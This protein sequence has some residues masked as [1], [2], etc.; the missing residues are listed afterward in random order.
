MI[1]TTKRILV[2]AWHVSYNKHSAT[3]ISQGSKSYFF[4]RIFMFLTSVFIFFQRF[5]SMTYTVFSVLQSRLA[6]RIM[7]STCPFVRSFVCL[8]STCKRYTLKMSEAISMQIGTNLPSWQW[9]A[10]STAGVRWSKVTVIG[11]QSYVQSGSLAET[12]FSIP[13]V[14]LIPV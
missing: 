7:F 3:K 1:Y 9:H 6:I 2:F 8:S 13:W 11:V 5:S 10:R 4:S 12:S 14:E